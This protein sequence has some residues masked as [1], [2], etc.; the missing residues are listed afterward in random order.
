MDPERLNLIDMQLTLILAV[1]N[2]RSTNWCLRLWSRFIKA[3]DGHQCVICRSSDRVQA[4]HIFRRSLYPYGWFQP[5][6]GITLCYE[7]HESQ[8]VEFNGRPDM[9]MPVDAEGG[10]NLDDAFRYLDSLIISANDN[11]H[12]HDEFY[13]IDDHMLIFFMRLQGNEHMQK[14]IYDDRFSRLEIAH[15]VWRCAPPSMM[16]ALARANSPWTKSA[17]ET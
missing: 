4:H 9:S 7:C 1:K 6:N 16:E 3:R 17:G 11:G 8:H 14:F 5:G 13:Y 10:D 12:E 2:G 15:E